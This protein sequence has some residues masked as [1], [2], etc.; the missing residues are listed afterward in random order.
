MRGWAFYFTALHWAY[1]ALDDHESAAETASRAQE[2]GLRHP[3]SGTWVGYEAISLA[4]LG[5]TAEANALLDTILALPAG[6]R[7]PLSWMIGISVAFRAAGHDE[8]ASASAERL[9]RWFETRP[10]EVRESAE[11]RRS[12]AHALNLSG[13]TDEAYALVNALVQEYP[14][15]LD[16]RGFLGVL[17]A[18]LGNRE[19]A[20]EVSEWLGQLDRPYLRGT[21]TMWQCHVDATL[22]KQEAAVSCLREAFQ[23]GRYHPGTW[24]I[25]HVF[26]EPLRDYPPFQELMRPKG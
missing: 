24:N 25:F 13:R 12:W 26:T 7:Y 23:Q 10:T 4:S 2:L 9:V 1:S 14:E 21:N 5:R 18:S 15:D 6:V 3:R 11:V 20:E 19:Q 17:A 22:G 16:Y 8:A